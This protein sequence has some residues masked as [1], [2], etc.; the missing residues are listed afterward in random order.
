MF[1]HVM[2]IKNIVFR[3]YEN[4][5]VMLISFSPLSFLVLSLS[6]LHLKLTKERVEVEVTI[7]ISASCFLSHQGKFH[8]VDRLPYDRRLARKPYLDE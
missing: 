7:L 6:V 8:L 4:I 5:Y 1:E 3:E 2:N